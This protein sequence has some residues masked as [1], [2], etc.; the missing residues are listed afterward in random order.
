MPPKAADFAAAVAGHIDQT[1]LDL[2]N[3][4]GTGE[5][6]ST[7]IATGNLGGDNPINNVNNIP[8]Q[9]YYRNMHVPNQQFGSNGK[10][11]IDY[12]LSVPRTLALKSGSKR[13]YRHVDSC[14][15]IYLLTKVT[16][17]S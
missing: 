14:C 6:S 12:R 8:N 7:H 4:V 9:R 10:P 3:L 5:N 2:A 13:K 17:N 1:I 16:R 15:I 11:L